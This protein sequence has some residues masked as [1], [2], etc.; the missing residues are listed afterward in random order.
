MVEQIK[1]LLGD[2]ASNYTD[3]QI[4]LYA[5]LAS[6][7]VAEYCNRELDAVL[8]LIAAQIAVI[9]LNRVGTEGASA[10]SFSG[11]SASYVDGYPLEIMKVLNAKR[12]IKVV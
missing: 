1:L 5:E 2:R 7:E 8:T 6:A 12:K 4:A 11:V 3:D 10:Q 9:K